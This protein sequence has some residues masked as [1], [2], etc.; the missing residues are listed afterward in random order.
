MVV[1]GGI[2]P[3]EITALRAE[4]ADAARACLSKVVF[5]GQEYERC[6]F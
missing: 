6:Q 5:V 3:A 4:D 2:R 1:N